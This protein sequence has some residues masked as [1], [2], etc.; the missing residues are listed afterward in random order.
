[1]SCANRKTVK[2]DRP[3]AV[4]TD[5]FKGRDGLVRTVEVEMP[6]SAAYI[7]RKVHPLIQIKTIHRGTKSI[8]LL[9]ASAEDT[10]K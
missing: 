8:I 5:V 2:Y 3:T 4:I 10:T 7:D 6:H 1:M 9:E